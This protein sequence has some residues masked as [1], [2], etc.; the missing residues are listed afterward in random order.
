MEKLPLQLERYFFTHQEVRA[1]P[2][3]DQAGDRRGTHILTD[4]KVNKLEEKGFYAVEFSVWDDQQNSVN[5]PYF[6]KLSVFGVFTI[7]SDIPDET[8]VALVG[9]AGLQ[10]MIGVVRERL[11][12]LTSRGPWATLHLNV[13]SMMSALDTDKREIGSV[14][15][16]H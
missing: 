10:L 12:E 8:S 15:V 4:H 13:I 9:T 14:A 11:A 1:N 5:Q 3:Y 7:T 6:F 2:A 16:S